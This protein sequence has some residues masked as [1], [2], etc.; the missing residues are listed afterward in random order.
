VKSIRWR[1]NIPIRVKRFATQICKCIYTKAN[2]FGFFVPRS[3][4]TLFSVSLSLSSCLAISICLIPRQTAATMKCA[5][6]R[7][8][9]FFDECDCKF[10]LGVIFINN[11][12]W[13]IWKLIMWNSVVRIQSI[14]YFSTS[15]QK[16]KTLLNSVFVEL[17]KTTIVFVCWKDEANCFYKF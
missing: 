1:K 8:L 17:R 7:F 13:L 4:G 11:L 16:Q 3:V 12:N 2:S 15:S 5:K 6:S 10:K 9:H 14:P